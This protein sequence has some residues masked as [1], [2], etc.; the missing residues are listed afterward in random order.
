M[1]HT[2]QSANRFPHGHVRAEA[3]S[4]RKKTGI[5]DISIVLPFCNERGNLPELLERLQNTLG[6]VGLTY[7]LIFV[8]DGST[9]DGA[10]FLAEVACTDERIKVLVLSRNFGQH[11]AG[12][13]GI[14]AAR[15]RL[16]LWMDT[17]LQERPEDIPK[18]IAK[19][20]EGFEVVYARRKCREQGRLRALTSH[21]Y[22]GLL[23]RLAAV[24]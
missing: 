14:D 20:R 5:P 11:I 23:N 22:L 3:A 21:T 17:D 2:Q 6:R 9:D 7:E 12:T 15:G 18:F 19:Q 13:A 24:F 1:S 8:D 4:E 16:V 10:A